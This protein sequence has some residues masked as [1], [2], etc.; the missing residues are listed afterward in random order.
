MVWLVAAVSAGSA[1]S[2][3][4]KFEDCEVSC[5]GAGAEACPDGFSCV[6]GLCRIDGAGTECQ[7]PG[8]LTLRQT[9]DDKV[10]R[11][12]VFGCTNPDTT[13]APGSWYRVFPLAQEG[14][15]ATFDVTRVTF[16]VC[17]AVG[18]PT[19]QVKVGSYAGGAADASLDLAQVTTIQTVDVP[20]AATQISKTID[21][22]ITA[23]VPPGNLIV[24][25]V[26]P[27][28]EGTSQEVNMGFTAAAEEKPGYVRSPLCGPATPM[29][30]S[31]AGLPNAHLVLS[32][33][34]TTR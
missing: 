21:V 29:T 8:E 20:V 34:G 2:Y 23:A 9:A 32:V 18:S 11:S 4:V 1:C 16:G 12:L 6:G 17:F 5:T 13:T 15:A 19:V 31:G 33:T 24:E 27:D 22:P 25:L 26:V 10:E 3:G 7:A 14:I 28:L 30:T